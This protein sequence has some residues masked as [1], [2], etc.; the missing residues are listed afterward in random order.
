LY[1]LIFLANGGSKNLPEASKVFKVY[2][3]FFNK[4]FW[5][6]SLYFSF[7]NTQE[8]KL[9]HFYTTALL[10]FPINLIPWRDSNLGLLVP[11]ADAM[12]TAPCR[13]GSAEALTFHINT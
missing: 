4:Y 13:Q 5:A 8:C 3:Y 12:S 11:E 1:Q 7:L 2:I 9:S 6:Q 10:C